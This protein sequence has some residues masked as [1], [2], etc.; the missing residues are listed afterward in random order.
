[1]PPTSGRR[2]PAPHEAAR[3]DLV[4]AGS[5]FGAGR[6]RVRSVPGVSGC[7]RPSACARLRTWLVSCGTS[8]GESGFTRRSPC[9]FEFTAERRP[10]LRARGPHRCGRLR[11][12]P[13]GA[14]GFA[15]VRR[16]RAGPSRTRERGAR[17]RIALSA[18][19]TA[20]RKRRVPSAISTAATPFRFT[21]RSPCDFEFTPVRRPWLRARGPHRCG[22]LRSRPSGA[23]RLCCGSGGIEQGRRHSRSWAVPVAP[24]ALASR[25]G[26]TDEW[27]APD[28]RHPSASGR[29]SWM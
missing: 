25:R 19:V 24:S 18:R 23:V 13:S 2:T 3:F 12:R 29:W 9:D 17:F 15:A 20:R 8:S 22:R 27:R 7:V 4:C 14:F 16:L 6:L 26:P 5:A 21:R 1:M 11:S 28:A 10:W